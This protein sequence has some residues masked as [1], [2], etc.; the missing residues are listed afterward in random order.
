MDWNGFVGPIVALGFL[1]SVACGDAGA[2]AEDDGGDDEVS[3][4]QTSTD[5]DTDT[6]AGEDTD[7]DTGEDP[8]VETHPVNHSFGTYALDPFEEVSPCVQWTLDNEAAV[9]AQA[10]TLSNEGYFHHSNWFVVPEDVFEG[11]DGYFDC[12][13]RGFTEIAATLLGTVLTAQSTQSFTETQRT[14]D[15]AVIKIPAGHKVIGATHMLNVGPAP[16]ETELFMGLEF[17]HPKDVTAILGPF[18]L[19]YF[20]LDIPAQSEA[21]FTARCGEFGQEYEDAMGIPP[22][23][24]LHYVLPHFHYLGN[25]FQLSF[26]GGNL[27]QPQV[28]EHSGF[29]GD[30]NGLTF[31]PPIDLSDITGLDFTCGYDNWRD[32][33][34]GWGIGDQEM[35][36][37][38]GLAESEGLT[39]ISVHEGTVAVGEQDGIIQFEGPCSTIVSA[40][41][42]AQGP[43]TQA[44]RD[45]PLYLPEGG[46]AELPA[47]PECVD[48][49][50][51]AAP[52]IEPTLDN[53]ATVIFEQSCAFNACHGQSNP[54]AGLDLISP[55]LHGRLLDHEVLGDPGA[56]LVEPGD[57]DNSWLYQRVA[58]CEPQSGEGVSVTHMPLNAPI[59]LSDPSVALLREWIAAGAM[60]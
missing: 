16:I 28:Y 49:D 20:D 2:P 19:T 37:M 38:L 3:P 36:V 53:V 35:C 34:V 29:N 48:H 60:P 43:P 32:V 33:P 39:D 31:D 55:G 54:A 50:P 21:R 47:V 14:Q 44:E 13:A 6:D 10:V 1:G 52:A 57:P 23:H 11:P 4:T 22:D 18:R 58:E 30:A 46:D 7:T 42:P 17:I 56:S 24:K 26:T 45:G 41:N 12:E 25:Y 59:L 51:N 9:Y 5:E 8:G 40:P 15:G 27:E